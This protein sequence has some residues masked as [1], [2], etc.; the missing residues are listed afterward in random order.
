VEILIFK[1]TG[2]R[3]GVSLEMSGK[4]GQSRKVLNLSQRK[5]TGNVIIV[6]TTGKR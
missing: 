6:L 1:E 4:R 5:I 3:N 2:S